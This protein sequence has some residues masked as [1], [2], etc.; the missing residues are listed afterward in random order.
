MPLIERTR[1]LAKTAYWAQVA[2]FLYEKRMC[3]KYSCL[4]PLRSGYTKDLLITVPRMFGDFI[5]LIVIKNI[6]FIKKERLS[7]LVI[8][9]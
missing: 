1:A 5:Y 3:L 9:R 7:A 6:Y 8:L 4:A 2:E